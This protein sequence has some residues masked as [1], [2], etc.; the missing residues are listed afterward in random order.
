[1]GNIFGRSPEVA[2]AGSGSMA[3][4]MST[5][6]P[7]F[8]LVLLVL[9]VF[10]VLFE[11]GRMDV[12]SENEGQRVTPPYEMLQSGDFVVP[13]LNGE[14]YLAKPPLLYWAIAGM[15]A[16]TD[17]VDEY[18]GRLPSAI[19]SICLVLL[20]Y[21]LFSPRIGH[22]AAAFAALAT[23]GA[24]YVLERARWAE[25]DVPLTLF[26]FLAI[27]A[28][29]HAWSATDVRRALILSVLSGMALAAATMLKG[30]VPFLFVAMALL[31]RVVISGN[32]P[33]RVIRLGILW[34][35]ICAGVELLR[36]LLAL[37]S[38]ALYLPLPI[39]L[40]LFCAGWIFL[41]VRDRGPGWKAAAGQAFIAMCVAIALVAPW[42]I[43]VV[44]RLGWDYIRALLDNQVVERTYT[45]SRINSGTP[46]YFL[47]AL[48]FM[49]APWGFLLPL[50]F[51]GRL[52]RSSRE[53][54]RFSAA[55]GWLSVA[56]FSLIAGKEYEYILPALPFLL[57]PLGCN[58]AAYLDDDL[59]AFWEKWMR[60][61]RNSAV[62]LLAL[63]AL[64]LP[65][66]IVVADFNWTFLGESIILGLFVLALLF[67]PRTEERRMLRIGAATVLVVLTVLLSRAF[68][69]TGE[70]SPKDLAL[71]CRDLI[72]NGH[73]L[74]ATK[75]Y[76]SFAF[77]AR[78]PI[79]EVIDPDVV[80]EKFA[81]KAPYYYL[82]R[83]EFVAG[84]SKNALE[85][86]HVVEGP[87]RLKDLV[88][89]SNR[90]L[91]AA[92]EEFPTV[93]FSE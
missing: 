1:M 83:E 11:L 57:A 8:L 42:A 86:P 76:A 72:E 77:Y 59:P 54:Y 88:L 4:S 92:S 80:I 91:S 78:H 26:I 28:L 16:A 13:T 51:S 9:T 71:L 6:R 25:L 10:A 85:P 90:K 79:P 56:L 69:Y 53:F 46:F 20:I 87:I 55:T 81:G 50:Q 17:F 34:S 63:C 75:V 30:P 62:G 52:W 33:E 40:I 44:Q 3:K 15:Y 23:L 24:P 14:V 47:L 60:V 29:Y 74:E 7:A 45:A 82:T 48:P 65:I 18:T 67:A 36:M 43:A 61:W 66:Y 58:I 49:L 68:H 41:A 84:F 19:A 21:L 93:T 32:T 37:I 2:K 12:V 35:A 31:A 64:G 89:L 39:G 27:L 70:R 38:P 22:R 73:T 5:I